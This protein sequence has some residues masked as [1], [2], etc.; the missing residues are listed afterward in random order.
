MLGSIPRT[1]ALPRKL[2]GVS[3]ELASLKQANTG[4]PADYGD[5][6]TKTEGTKSGPRPGS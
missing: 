1:R 5:L 2:N 3:G 6:W 4:S